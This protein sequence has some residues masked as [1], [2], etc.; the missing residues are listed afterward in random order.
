MRISRQSYYFITLILIIAGNA[1]ISKAQ[2]NTL[3][4]MHHVPQA[5]HSNPAI[6]YHCK[7]YIEIPVISSI[8]QSYG[9][10]GFGYHDAIHYGSGSNAD[11]LIIDMDN[12]EKK[13]KKRNY[14]NEDISVNLMGAGF[15]LKEDY[16]VHFNVALKAETRVGF[17][18]GLVALKDGNWDVN[19]GVPRDINLSGLG[20]KATNYLQFAAGVC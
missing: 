11:S 6:F 2:N 19:A 17:P 13:L 15:L 7:T 9:N 10:T 18:G 3:Y 20:V 4:F 8:S 16:Y 1:S 5:I 12:L 14:I